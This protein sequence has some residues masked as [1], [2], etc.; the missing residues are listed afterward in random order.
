[1][2]YLDFEL[3]IEPLRGHNYSVAVVS[4]PAGEARET[5]R[6]PFSELQRGNRLQS[7]ENALVRS[8]GSRRRITSSQERAVRGFH[9]LERGIVDECPFPTSS[10]CH[11]RQPGH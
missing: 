11:R 10:A 2:D 8:T 7:L 5:M 6:F 3:R 9:E 1:V 4:S